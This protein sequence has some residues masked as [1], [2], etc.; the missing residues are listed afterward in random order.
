MATFEKKV[1]ISIGSS[2]LF[3]VINY[4]DTY[5][6]TTKITK[7]NLFDF[8]TQCPTLLGNMIHTIA[9]F[10]LTFVSMQNPAINVGIKLKH[11]IYGS[12][13]SFFIS[14]PVTYSFISSILGKQFANNNGCPTLAG[15]ILHTII[16]CICL[17]GVMYLP[18]QNK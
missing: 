6:F 15:I 11:T 2:V 8:N 16:Y 13:I 3:F 9:F 14:N 12:L 4:P 5:K 10:I 7:L 18:E 1:L 17:I